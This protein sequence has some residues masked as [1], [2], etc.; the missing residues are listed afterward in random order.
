VNNPIH[1]PL[2]LRDRCDHRMRWSILDVRCEHPKHGTTEHMA[3]TSIGPNPD[4]TVAW[5]DGDRRDF[6]GEHPGP[7]DSK[8]CLLPLNHH[9]NHAV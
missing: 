3:H 9:G 8:G 4:Q 7:C 1:I 5:Q 6:V 2:N